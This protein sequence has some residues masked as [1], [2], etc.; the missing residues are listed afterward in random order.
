MFSWENTIKEASKVVIVDFVRHVQEGVKNDDASFVNS[1][2]D[3]SFDRYEALFQR[4]MSVAFGVYNR[5]PNEHFDPAVVDSCAEKVKSALSSDKFSM[6][7]RNPIVL[8]SLVDVGMTVL[9]KAREDH[10]R[11]SKAFMEGVY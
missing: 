2:V 1:G 4:T 6:L 11:L 10:F 9:K 8:E 5:V 7:L 3:S